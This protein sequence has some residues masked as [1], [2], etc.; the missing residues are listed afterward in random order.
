MKENQEKAWELLTQQ[1]KNSLL[2]QTTHGQSSWEAGEIM[3]ISHYKYLELK[4]RSVKFFKMFSEYFENHSCLVM[5]NCPV[6]PRFR[7]YIEGC[8]EKRLDKKDAILYS[9]DSA[10][11]VAKL[12]NKFVL[13]NM[14]I[15]R[16]SDN[17]L[18]RQ[19]YALIMEFDRWNNKRILPR[20]IQ[21][22]S[23]YKR[24]NNNRDKT[25]LNYICNLPDYKVNAIIDIY[26]YNFRDEKAKRWYI[27]LI[28]PQY[29]DGYLVIPIKAK[30]KVLEALSKLSI[31]I[32]DTE[33]NA[34]VFGFIVTR[35]I[36]NK[37]K[38]PKN[39]QKF[40]V[41]YREHIERAINYNLV[42]NK[43]FYADKLDV[44]YDIPK[45]GRPP[46]KKRRKKDKNKAAKRANTE[47]FYS[48]K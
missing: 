18:D 12:K 8:I 9:G 28:T 46:L 38:D 7:D 43:N 33:D 32:F 13:K 10:L 16:K 23:A 35:F 39:G 4:E 42:N 45:G 34:D 36:H 15:L 40:W 24:R 41:N 14:E 25:Y 48:L 44:A 19:L 37:N 17:I 29:E 6:H 1:E 26:R 30:D 22:P 21:L 31:F 3:G 47:L 27:C 2:L 20:S 5:P 11:Q